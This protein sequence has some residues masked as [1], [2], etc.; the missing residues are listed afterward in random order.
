MAAISTQLDYMRRQIMKSP[1][2]KYANSFEEKT[3][4][5]SEYVVVGVMAIL[6]ALLFAGVGGSLI[7]NV[8]G[9]IY[10][11]VC[12]IKAIE[13]VESEDDT[14]WLVRSTPFLPFPL[15]LTHFD[16]LI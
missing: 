10:P 4:I 11:V 15:F 8:V 13:S 14:Q 16:S 5:N 1:Y 6:A 3:K 7:V 12:S 9:F 2:A